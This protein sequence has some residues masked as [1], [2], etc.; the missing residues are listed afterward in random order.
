MLLKELLNI[1]NDDQIIDLFGDIKEIKHHARAEDINEPDLLDKEVEQV[2][3]SRTDDR[4]RDCLTVFIKTNDITLSQFLSTVRDNEFI[5]VWGSKDGEYKKIFAGLK[6]TFEAHEY[7]IG[8]QYWKQR[9]T[10][11]QEYEDD[12]GELKLTIDLAEVRRNEARRLV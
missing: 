9:V 10:L 3:I 1:L 2:Y 8:L 5:E 11:V 7:S 4:Y 12:D 6:I